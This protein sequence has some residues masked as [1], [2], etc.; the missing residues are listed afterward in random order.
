ME[1]LQLVIITLS[2]FLFALGGTEISPTIKGKRWFR[3]AILPIILGGIAF[4]NG[5]IYW[6]AIGFMLCLVSAL[7][8]PYGQKTSYPMK[9]LTFIA[10]FGSTLWIGFSWWIVISPLLVLIMF[11]LSNWK[12]T[13]NIVF[14]KAW[15]FLTGAYLGITVASLIGR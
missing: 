7:T 15:E 10:I 3:W 13:A 8:L 9:L 6:K 1:F 4:F 5:L 12:W 14:W 2:A 11:A